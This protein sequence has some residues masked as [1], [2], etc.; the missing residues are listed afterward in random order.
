V[1][2]SPLWVI[3]TEVLTE[4]ADRPAADAVLTE[5]PETVKCSGPPAVIAETNAKYLLSP[6]AAN[7]FFVV[8][9][10]TETAENKEDQMTGTTPLREDRA[11]KDP[12]V[13]KDQVITTDLRKT[14]ARSRI[15]TLSLLNSALSSTGSSHF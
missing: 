12:R 4:T 15:I 2:N 11:L 9:V 14:H 1:Y 8:N 10:S 5:T 7:P 3:L 6:T 13:F